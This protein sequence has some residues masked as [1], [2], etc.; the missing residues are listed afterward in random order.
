MHRD[1]ITNP[2]SYCPRLSDPVPF[3]G[4]ALPPNIMYFLCVYTY[5]HSRHLFVIWKSSTLFIMCC[6]EKVIL[7]RHAFTH[8]LLDKRV[9][10]IPS[11]FWVTLTGKML[12][13][14]KHSGLTDKFTFLRFFVLFF[15][16][17]NKT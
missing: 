17:F 11:V 10:V 5:T 2:M 6:L 14:P 16:N 12:L 8:P 7:K 3:S 1:E 15:F 9:T 13:T 4:S